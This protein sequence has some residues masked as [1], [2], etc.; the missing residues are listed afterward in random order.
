MDM[1]T[2]IVSQ[3]MHPRQR[4][5][6]VHAAFDRKGFEGAL[7]AD[8]RLAFACVQGGSAGRFAAV[9]G[10]VD[11]SPFGGAAK[12]DSR[13]GGNGSRCRIRD[14]RGGLILRWAAAVSRLCGTTHQ[15]KGQGKTR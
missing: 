4:I 9:Q 7:A 13:T 5:A 6:V 11:G 8:Y 3:F 12:G 15:A 2:K 1:L 10:V 14:R